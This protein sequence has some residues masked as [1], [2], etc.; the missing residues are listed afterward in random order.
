MTPR[1]DQN[2]GIVSF[3]HP[4]SEDPSP[5]SDDELE[6][7]T[8]AAAAGDRAA[9][10]VLLER[11]LP[12]LRAFVR[13]KSGPIV[14]RHEAHSDIV[15]SIC[16]EVLTHAD[17]FQHPSEGAFRRWLF[18]TA[19]RKLSNRR[20]HLLRE[21]RDV[22][23]TAQGSEA[24]AALLDAYAQIS[25]PSRHAAMR[26]E[27]ERFEGAMGKLSESDRALIVLARIVGLSRVE[28]AEEMGVTPDVVRTRLHRA[29]TRLAAELRE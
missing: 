3:S 19:L 14:R 11:L 16:R 6:R 27:L 5:Q 20:D 25:T 13:L 23:R 26:E 12:D 4:M 24:D 9:L 15:Q 17:R 8:E 22:A 10:E 7:L 21:R 2:P 18:T 1:R 29:L 28:L